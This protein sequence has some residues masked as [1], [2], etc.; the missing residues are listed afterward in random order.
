M[1]VGKLNFFGPGEGPG[2]SLGGAGFGGSFGGEGGFG[3][4]PDGPEGPVGGGSFGMDPGAF[5]GADDSGFGLFGEGLMGEQG[6]F[7]I[8]GNLIKGKSFNA[9]D[10]S[11]KDVLM[12]ALSPFPIIGQA[13]NISKGLDF[14][15]GLVGGQPDPVGAADPGNQVG[16]QGVQ[17]Q[18]M[19]KLENP[20]LYTFNRPDDLMRPQ[21]NGPGLM[22]APESAQKTA[23][24]LN[25]PD[26]NMQDSSN[27]TYEKLIE[28]LINK[29]V[30]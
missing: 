11:S 8:L 6:L 3:G 21:S 2:G 16:G 26:F 7:D 15:A 12:A 29:G 24:K 20:N 10:L 18:Q 9:D 25:I 28:Y 13:E 30:A 17:T 22:Q 19:P 4:G 1:L 5:L 27:P 14:A 23:Q